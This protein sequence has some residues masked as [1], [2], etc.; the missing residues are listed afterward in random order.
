M[1]SALGFVDSNR[2]L[3]ILETTEAKTD[4]T[5]Y[6]KLQSYYHAKRFQ[7]QLVR[8]ASFYLH[9]I[10]KASVLLHHLRYSL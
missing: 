1:V 9:R 4:R 7:A 3:V 2:V 5:Q 10:L 6:S 8:I